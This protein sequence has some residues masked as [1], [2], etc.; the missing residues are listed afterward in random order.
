MTK[1]PEPTK[2]RKFNAESFLTAVLLGGLG[3]GMLT[4]IIYELHRL[5]PFY[6]TLGLCSFGVG[7]FLAAL[8]WL[9]FAEPYS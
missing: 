9:T 2:P 4:L 3:S 1:V 6:T 5:S 7:A 8:T